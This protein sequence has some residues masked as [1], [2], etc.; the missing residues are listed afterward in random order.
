MKPAWLDQ[1]WRAALAPEP[2]LLVSEW[3]DKYRQ[4]PSTSAEPGPWRTSRTPYLA[5]IMDALSTGA[6]LERV[7]LMKGAQLGATECGLNWLGYIV[8]H[9]PGLAL[10]VMPSLDMA[11][12]NARTR[13]DPM[14]EA[15]PVLRERIAAPRSRNAYNSAFVKGFPG[16]TL[17]LTGANS[18]AALRST[19]ARYLCLDEVDSYPA[20]CGGEGD[21]VA[22]AIARAQTFK[23]RR[24]IFM[25][26]TPTVAGVSRI[27]KAYLEGDQRR[28]E[29]ACIHCGAFAPIEWKNIRWPEGH[30]EGAELHCEAC[31]G[32]MHEHDKARLLASGAWRATAP[33][34]QRT[35]SFHI[36]AL[37]SPFLTWAE[38]AIEHGAARGDPPRLQA[39]QNLMLGE[40]YEDVAA[41]SL[42]V[43]ELQRRAESWGDCAPAG[44]VVAVAGVDVQDD[45]CE[46]EICGFGLGDESWSLDYQVIYGDPAGAEL[47]QEVDT[48]L[49]E[50]VTHASGQSLPIRAACIDSGGHHTQDVYNYV[51]DKGARSIWATKGSSRPGPAWPRKPVKV[52]RTRVTPLYI[53]GVDT[54]KDAL[55]ARLRIEDGAGRCHFPVG[56]DATWFAGLT[57]ERPIRRFFKGVARREWTKTQGA[58]NEP[59]DCRILC[60]AALE[61]L[62]ASGLRLEIEAERLKRPTAPPRPAVVRSK[63]MEG[64]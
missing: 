12:R 18:A 63:W 58:R 35:A 52:G 57:S 56:R 33:G 9:A 13:L 38:V 21:P 19:P 46:V 32:I 61:G 40:P 1:T 15:C 14:I 43:G 54:L 34:D 24:R 11:R 7:V 39:W 29:V 41:Q 62:K 5:G 23:G 49:R 3:A 37:Y 20:D 53:I 17:V 42:P 16:G 22:L 64:L 28:F 4:L 45:R 44:V 59:L 47:W 26:S 51:R 31:G 55:A 27:E 10:M 2:A 8:A 36:S 48:L 25:A 50:R 30:R 60:M 6:P